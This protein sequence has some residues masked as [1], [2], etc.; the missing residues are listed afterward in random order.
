L[1]LGPTPGLNSH[2]QGL[3]EAGLGSSVFR[4]VFS[5]GR[6]IIIDFL[7][8]D[9]QMLRTAKLSSIDL[10]SRYLAVTATFFTLEALG[11]SLQILG[12]A[13]NSEFFYRN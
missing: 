12:M 6:K 3:I 10:K 4:F 2:L 5:A 7:S 1:G 13:W 11:G 8:L 9:Y